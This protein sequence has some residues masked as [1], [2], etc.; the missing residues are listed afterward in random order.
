MTR[1]RHL[2]TATALFPLAAL[3]LTGCAVTDT[4]AV[5]MGDDA[6]FEVYATTGYLADAVAHLAPEAEVATMVGPGGNR[7]L[8]V[9]ELLPEELLMDWPETD[10]EGNALFDPHVWNS[11]EAWS[12]VVGQNDN[13]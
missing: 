1:R 2:L 4:T 10:D 11:P 9:G 5:A 3:A 8:A 7:Q 13:G 12:P 6:L